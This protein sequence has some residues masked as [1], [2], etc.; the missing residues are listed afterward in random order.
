MARDDS[1]FSKWTSDEVVEF[2]S[3]DDDFEEPRRRIGWNYQ[4]KA[5]NNASDTDKMPSKINGK[6]IIKGETI[7]D[8]DSDDLE[9]IEVNP[10]PKLK[11]NNPTPKLKSAKS[12]VKGNNTG[13]FASSAD[14]SWRSTAY[15]WDDIQHF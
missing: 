4:G 12:K 5:I 8:S 15:F 10:T 6:H 11:S 1:K 3:S 13:F 7:S 14:R 9:V 2:D